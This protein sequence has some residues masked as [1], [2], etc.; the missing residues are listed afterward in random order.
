MGEDWE[1]IADTKMK[2]EKKGQE[3]NEKA[4][5]P[6][7]VEDVKIV[8]HPWTKI[9]QRRQEENK[10]RGQEENKENRAKKNTNELG[11]ERKGSVADG[12]GGREDCC[13]SMDED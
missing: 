6:M 9:K 8:A 5:L 7:E 12:S 11:R 4:A 2:T 3:E 1:T 10:E 13:T